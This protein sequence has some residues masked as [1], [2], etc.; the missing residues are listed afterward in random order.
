MDKIDRY[1]L[2]KLVISFRRLERGSAQACEEH[3]DIQSQSSA[4]IG[5]NC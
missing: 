1:I 5:L 4:L 2:T 3:S